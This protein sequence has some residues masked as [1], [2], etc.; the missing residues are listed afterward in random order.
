MLDTVIALKRPGDYTPDKGACFEIHFEKAR[1]IYGDD[2]KAFESQLVTTPDGR[3]TWATK[4]LEQSTAE[5]VASLLNEGIPQQEIAEM[6]GISK[7]G[8]S[9]AKKRAGELGMLNRSAA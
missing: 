1:G 9:K 3:Q 5:K 7:G 6:L 4:P 8:V 2:T